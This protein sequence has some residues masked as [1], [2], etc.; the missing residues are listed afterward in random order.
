MVKKIINIS[1]LNTFSKLDNNRICSKS[2]VKTELN[3]S[4]ES[5]I[6]DLKFIKKQKKKEKKK[7]FKFFIEEILIS[8]FNWYLEKIVILKRNVNLNSNDLIESISLKL[9]KITEIVINEI[10]KKNEENLNIFSSFFNENILKTLLFTP[11]YFNLTVRIETMKLFSKIFFLKE[12]EKEDEKIYLFFKISEILTLKNTFFKFKFFDVFI[13]F[14]FILKIF[15]KILIDFEILEILTKNEKF[16]TLIKNFISFIE[17][18]LNYYDISQD[19][20]DVDDDDIKD[21]ESMKDINEEDIM[22][23]EEKEEEEEDNEMFK[24]RNEDDLVKN[25]R[26]F[27]YFL[28]QQVLNILRYLSINVGLK[29]FTSNDYDLL[30]IYSIVKNHQKYLKNFEFLSKNF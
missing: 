19:D 3:K 23:K 1:N 21:D 13:F 30:S 25:E 7:N 28:V 27:S 4:N 10:L 6:L 20:E 9:L 17:N 5:N 22:E 11:S 14:D 16:D 15:S 24:I 26:L 18:E 29:D 12:E 2:N 8:T